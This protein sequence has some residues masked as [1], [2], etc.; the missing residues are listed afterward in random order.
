MNWKGATACA[1]HFLPL[2]TWPSPVARSPTT[3]GARHYPHAEIP[4]KVGPEI[5][6]FL[7]AAKSA[8][9]A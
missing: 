2:S 5:V 9:A 3:R 7:A 8:H 1:T 6:R 4:E